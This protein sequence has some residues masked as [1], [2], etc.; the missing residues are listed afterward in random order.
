ML[1]HVKPQR[2]NRI[3]ATAA[4]EK[5]R[6]ER[7]RR[8]DRHPNQT[9]TDALSEVRFKHSRAKPFLQPVYDR[10]VFQFR[11]PQ[12]S[13]ADIRV[14]RDLI[15]VG[16]LLKIEVCDHVIIL[17][18]PLDNMIYAECR[19]MPSW[20]QPSVRFIVKAARPP[21]WHLG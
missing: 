16:Q 4:K 19:I 17:S 9:T 1:Q 6:G 7:R 3:R 12:P 15:R 8:N 2:E 14:T 10:T 21:D 13:E 11:E 5:G 18:K 20:C